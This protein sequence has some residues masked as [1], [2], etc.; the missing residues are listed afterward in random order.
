MVLCLRHVSMLLVWLTL[1]PGAMSAEAT[2][3]LSAEESRQRAEQAMAEGNAVLAA[4]W[5]RAAARQGNAA[6]QVY[7]GWL[8]R[9]GRGV[10]QDDHAALRWFFLAAAQGNAGAE[11][12]LGT[13]YENGRGIPTDKAA[14]ARW[15]R[16]AAE[17]GNAQAQNNLGWLYLN[18]LGVPQDAAEAV[19]WFR[20]AADQGQPDAIGNLGLLTY[21]GRGVP[22]DPVEGLTL[23]R[24]AA[25]LGDL[26]AAAEVIRLEAEQQRQRAE[27]ERQRRAETEQRRRA[28]ADRRQQAAAAARP[29]SP[30]PSPSPPATAPAMTKHPG[31]VPPRPFGAWRSAAPVVDMGLRQ[32]FL[33][34][35]I[36]ANAVT[37]RYDCQYL[38]GSRLSGRFTTRAEVG[39]T[40]I[41]I[42]ERGQSRSED[43]NNICVASIRPVILP[44]SLRGD[45][46]TVTFTDKPVNL[47]RLG[48]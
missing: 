26:E 34:M 47:R 29:P 22:R 43:A 14:A 42:L 37:F 27:A 28:E 2:N 16:S 46:L 3:R 10:P 21:Q 45:R 48:G 8:H 44:Y 41:R 17:K 9:L 36:R 30:S 19:L 40:A 32:M 39:P 5:F 33:R 11:F 20:R 23:L 1:A 18:G 7:F 35:D 25:D 4:Q 24:R 15:Y 38:D 12:S 31:P 13:M 6:A